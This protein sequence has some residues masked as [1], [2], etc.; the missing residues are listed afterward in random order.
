MRLV[1]SALNMDVICAIVTCRLFLVT[2][3]KGPLS[4]TVML[5][6]IINVTS[7]RVSLASVRTDSLDDIVQLI[8]VWVF[9]WNQVMMVSSTITFIYCRYLTFDT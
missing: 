2:I 7:Q 1:S 6:S 4:A 9:L 3:V 5:T 8:L